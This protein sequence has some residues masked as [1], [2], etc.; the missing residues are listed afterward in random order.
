MEVGGE[1]GAAPWVVGEAMGGVELEV[2]VAS[3]VV[4]Q[5]SNRFRNVHDSKSMLHSPPTIICTVL[6]LKIRHENNNLA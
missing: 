6:L 4:L 1:V 3:Q 2:G 5:L